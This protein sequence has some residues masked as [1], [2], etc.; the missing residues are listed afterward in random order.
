MAATRFQ[1]FKKDLQGNDTLVGEAI[2]DYD[3]AKDTCSI[4]G[5]A[6]RVNDTQTEL[7]VVFADDTK[8]VGIAMNNKENIDCA[9]YM[10]DDILC[11][12]V[13]KYFNDLMNVF[14]TLENSF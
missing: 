10:K 12:N 1:L 5:M 3:M 9:I 14:D 8:K 6:F 7:I 13:E 4:P 2:L 11:F